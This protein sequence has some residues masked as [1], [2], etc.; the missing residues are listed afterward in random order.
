M[1]ENKELNEDALDETAGGGI[2]QSEFCWFTPAG[3]VEFIHGAWRMN[4]NSFCGLVT[5]CCC[6]NHP[7]A[8][9]EKWHMIVPDNKDGL[10]LMNYLSPYTFSNHCQKHPPTYNTK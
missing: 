5:T 3:K 6:Y 2:D 10:G 9:R 8:C 7:S 1:D 4:C